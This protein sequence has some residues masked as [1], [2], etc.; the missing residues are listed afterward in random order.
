M[1]FRS[2]STLLRWGLYEMVMSTNASRFAFL[3]NV[4]NNS[5]FLQIGTMEVNPT[6]VGARLCF[7]KPPPRRRICLLMELGQ[8]S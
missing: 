8:L 6:N 7:T 2:D 4:Y 1:L 5:S 3:A